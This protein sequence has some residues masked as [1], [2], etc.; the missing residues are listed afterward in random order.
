MQIIHLHST[1]QVIQGFG[2]SKDGQ[3]AMFNFPISKRKLLENSLL[4]VKVV[5]L[6]QNLKI[7]KSHVHKYNT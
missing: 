4:D 3:N 1:I 2:G 6:K 7:K 5:T